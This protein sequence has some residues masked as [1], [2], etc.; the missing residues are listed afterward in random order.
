MSIAF[1]TENA[2]GM[3]MVDSSW[4]A[5]QLLPPSPLNDFTLS[6]VSHCLSHS[7]Y[8]LDAGSLRGPGAAGAP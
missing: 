4:A 8:S 1:C 6:E 7:L 3:V 5:T 2:S